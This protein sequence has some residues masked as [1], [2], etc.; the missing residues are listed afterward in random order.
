MLC[1]LIAAHLWGF[2]NHFIIESTFVSRNLAD[3]VVSMA[4]IGGY[5]SDFQAEITFFPDTSKGN[6]SGCALQRF[7]IGIFGGR[8]KFSSEVSQ[9]IYKI[10]RRRRKI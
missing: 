1:R 6:S 5:L 7:Q 4:N 10:A 8:D 9:E 3:Y 2:I